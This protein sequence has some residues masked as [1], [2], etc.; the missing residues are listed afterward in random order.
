M[1]VLFVVNSNQGEQNATLFEYTYMR[2]TGDVWKY[3]YC[4]RKAIFYVGT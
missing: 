2:V 4:K 1:L 3:W